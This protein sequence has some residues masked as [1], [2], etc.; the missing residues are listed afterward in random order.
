M[1]IQAFIFNSLLI[2]WATAAAAQDTAQ[3]RPAVPVDPIAGVMDAF[4]SHPIVALG[5]GTHANEQGH[6]FRLALIRDPRFAATV[7]DIVVE[8]GNAKYQATIDRFVRG[9]NVPYDT[10]RLVWQNTT[11]PD[12][13]WD[14][15]IYEEFFRAVRS[16]NASLPKNRQLRVLLG[17]PPIDWDKVPAKDDYGSWD[18]DGH[19]ADVIR[20]EV[21]AKGRKALV[22]YGDLHFIRQ[23][24]QPRAGD[25]QA[26][27]SI[28]GLLERDGTKVFSIRT[29]AY[30]IDL[31]KLQADVLS[32]PRPSLT[33]LRGTA[34]G[35]ASFSSYYPRPLMVGADGKPVEA[36]EQR[37][38]LRMEE[39]FDAL[40]YLGPQSTITRSELL[41]ALC[42]DPAYLKMRMGRMEM[43]GMQRGIDRLKQQC[44]GVPVRQSSQAAP[45]APATFAITR[46]S[47]VDAITGTVATGM[48]VVVAGDTISAVGRDLAPPRGARIVDAAGKFLVPG[49]W[50]MHAHHE[51]TGIESLELFVANGVTGTRDMGSNLDFVLRLRDQVA[52]GAVAG[53]AVVAAGPILDDAPP[54]WPFRMRV[55]TPDEGRQAVRLLK[56]R[57][58][59]FVKVHDRTPRDVYFAIAREARAQGLAVDGHVPVDV[60]LREAQDEGQRTIEHLANFRVFTECSAGRVYRP[61]PCRPVF[62]AMARRRVWHTPTLAGAAVIMT[63]GTPADDGV[64]TH[65][66]YASPSLRAMWQANQ[67]ESNASPDGIRVFAELTRQ[68]RTAVGDLRRAGVGL[69]AGCD[70]LVPGFC[71]HDELAAMVQSGLTPLEAL[72]TA[73]INPA[74]MLGQEQRRGSI[75]AGKVADL[76]VLD[77][78]P[79]A[80]ISNTRR[81]H[82]VVARGRLFTRRDLDTMLADAR[83]RFSTKPRKPTS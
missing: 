26:A 12:T 67:Q 69:L 7:N 29:I 27:R 44:A 66:A 28:V 18:R 80:D 6:K 4:R 45:S 64:A 31:E 49:L 43:M 1:R 47:V 61:E 46:A 40:V 55:R 60:S 63:L 22:V 82:A 16:V 83:A 72:Q 68:A 50:D 15:P 2:G 36:P 79:L 35:T 17:D 39:Q 5:E 48:T 77:A 52:S 65:L 20:K 73:T 81:I 59:D 58:A 54:N 10:L 51:A 24:P 53:P 42:A 75:A 76:I 11:Q 19:P 62:E 9:D 38:R 14:A 34:L 30:G 70:A 74:R 71:L 78:N 23:N 32:W 25:E 37:R 57:G 3:P 21:L 8:S 56:A 41:P 33:L 13:L